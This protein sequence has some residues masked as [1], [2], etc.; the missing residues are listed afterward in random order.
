MMQ[1]ELQRA[2][3]EAELAKMQAQI[4]RP[5]VA[6]RLRS[7]HRLECQDF[8]QL[9]V[10]CGRSRCSELSTDG[11]VPMTSAV[12]SNSGRWSVVPGPPSW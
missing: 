5:R 7:L 6:D 1:L 4:G 12:V 10:G 8:R 11:L 2:K 3:R 9:V